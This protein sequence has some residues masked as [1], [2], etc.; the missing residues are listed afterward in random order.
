MDVAERVP[1]TLDFPVG[2]N[3]FLCDNEST[4]GEPS[5]PVGSMGPG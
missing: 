4:K 5:P 1:P 3:V 2:Q